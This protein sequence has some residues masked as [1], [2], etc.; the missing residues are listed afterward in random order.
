MSTRADNLSLEKIRQLL[1]AAGVE[2]QDDPSRNSAA[3]AFD[4]RC[5]R[6]FTLEQL[7]K[8]NQFA[9]T[10][11]AACI[12]LF[13][14]L[15]KGDCTVSVIST[16]QYFS[17][18]TPQ[19]DSETDD[20]YLPFGSDAKKPF[21]LL[22]IPQLSAL[23]WAGLMLGGADAGKETDRSLSRLEESFLA[24]IASSLI[25]AFAGAYG[26]V[27]QPGGPFYRD[28][29]TVALQ[30]SDEWLEIVF[31]T[32]KTDT[33]ESALTAAFLVCC[34][35]LETVAGKTASAKEK[36]SEAQIRSVMLGHIHQVPMSVRVELGTVMVAFKDVVN[37]QANDVLVLH[38]RVSGPVDV[39]VEDR[40]LFK[41][42][43]VQSGGRQAVVLC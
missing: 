37:L 19:A 29:S 41:G 39:L 7:A 14:R 24:D 2:S 16:R 31:Q 30:G 36:L 43:P 20:Y 15:Y 33:P 22:R 27:L 9:E 12:D 5:C 32:E 13:S 21:G 3:Q 17:S 38:Q 4:W 23:T 40:V 42:H 25:G 34:D 1:S 28:R 8:I 35:K 10:A 6:Y 26:A 11:A 18:A